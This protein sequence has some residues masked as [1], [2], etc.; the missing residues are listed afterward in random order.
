MGI[1]ILL[2]GAFVVTE[3]GWYGLD[4]VASPWNAVSSQRAQEQA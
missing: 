3:L 2:I 1:V 4:R